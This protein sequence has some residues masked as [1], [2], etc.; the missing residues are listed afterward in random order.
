M[1]R[2]LLLA[3]IA[4]LLAPTSS[5]VQA[6]PNQTQQ[7]GRTQTRL[8][9]AQNEDAKPEKKA[10]TPSYKSAWKQDVPEG[11]VRI[12]LADLT[13]DKKPR[14]L[15]LGKDNKLTV[16]D[17]SGEKPK[18]EDTLD[19]GKDADQFVVGRFAKGKPA[20][21]AIP[22][23]I[24][25]RDGDKYS[26]KEAADL[27]MITGMAHFADE[28]ENIL[29][30]GGMGAP[31]SFAVDLTGE[32]P[33]VAGKEMKDP[34]N[35]EGYY[36]H[37]IFRL[38]KEARESGPFPEEL[39]SLAAF[40][41]VAHGTDKKL[42]MLFPGK[43]DGDHGF[44]LVDMRSLQGGGSS[45]PVWKSPK[46]GGK[47][48]DFAVGADP[49]GSKKNGILVLTATGEGGKKRSVEFFAQE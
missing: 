7:S 25:Y 8:A 34:G 48:L 26:K 35:A 19:L 17:I 4:S 15:T 9:A 42:Y 44:G 46:I 47:I 23:T 16:S 49:K 40:T 18:E 20:V 21:I 14:L 39:K 24:Y 41:I 31:Q 37:I 29:V 1:R 5:V 28:A 43:A 10:G 12:A 33:L 45:N 38:P 32:K 2:F 3:G 36:S 27:K 30:G 11:T 22:G 6:S 13:D